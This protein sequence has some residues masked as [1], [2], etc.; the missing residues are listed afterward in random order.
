[1]NTA[2]YLLVTVKIMSY[3]HR[4]SGLRFSH[5]EADCVVLGSNLGQ[6]VLQVLSSLGVHVV[7]I[8]KRLVVKLSHRNVILSYGNVFLLRER[9]IAMKT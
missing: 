9:F 4:N 7:K 5:V 8:A 1:M 6:L 2:S 3:N